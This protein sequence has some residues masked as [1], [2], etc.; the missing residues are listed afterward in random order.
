MKA[1]GAALVLLAAIATAAPAPQRTPGRRSSE[2]PLDFS[3]F[4]RIDAIASKNINPMM[5]DSTLSVTQK[6]NRIWISPGPD[7][8]SGALLSEE[9]VVD[10]RPYEKS[11]G[12][13]GKGIV[14][15]DWAPDGQSLRIEARVGTE[16]DS[17]NFAIQRSIWK[18]S[19]DR[20][21]WV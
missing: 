3:G 1:A 8:K 12:P 2:A 18:L 5:K 13:A 16:G 19:S 9:I 10:G 20:T 6:G 14:T 17:Q 4:W 21:V 7:V 11:V 15:A